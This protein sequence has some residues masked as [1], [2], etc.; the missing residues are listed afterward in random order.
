VDNI[1]TIYKYLALILSKLL[2][3]GTLGVA[4]SNP[5]TPTI[6]F[7]VLTEH[8]GKDHCEVVGRV[9]LEFSH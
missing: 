8:I 2:S 3:F 9:V 7:R 4:R 6:D 1:R 5:V